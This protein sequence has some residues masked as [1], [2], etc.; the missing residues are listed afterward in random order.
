MK[1]YSR[2]FL[3]LI[4]QIQETVAA[5]LHKAVPAV[6]Q[7]PFVPRWRNLGSP[8]TPYHFLRPVP[9]KAQYKKH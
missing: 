9:V 7:K 3:K 5:H 1:F 6:S 4:N 8:V 2:N